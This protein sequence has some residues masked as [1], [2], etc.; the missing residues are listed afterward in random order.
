MSWVGKGMFK[1]DDYY[2][3]GKLVDRLFDAGAV[4]VTMGYKKNRIYAVVP[5]QR[6]KNV[7]DVLLQEDLEFTKKPG[8]KGKVF[9]YA[10]RW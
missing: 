4:A 7:E 3:L 5:V 6:A 1:A 8:L 10:V 2:H 9:I